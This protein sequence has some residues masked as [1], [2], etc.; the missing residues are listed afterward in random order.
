MKVV[1]SRWILRHESRPYGAQQGG[2]LRN[3]R[4]C[5]GGTLSASTLCW[6]FISPNR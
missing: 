6:L 4:K 2:K 1:A 3:A 5:D